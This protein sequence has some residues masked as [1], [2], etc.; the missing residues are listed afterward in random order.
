[1]AF[2]VSGRFMKIMSHGGSVPT[3][4]LLDNRKQ[5]G[6]GDFHTMA[7]STFAPSPSRSASSSSPSV[8]APTTTITSKA[9]TRIK[10]NASFWRHASCLPFSEDVVPSSL[11]L[12]HRHFLVVDV[13]T[14]KL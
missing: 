9:K 1:M 3:G 4:Y 14:Q 2:N 5:S 13:E 11:F 6:E 7:T 10:L 12:K 8:P